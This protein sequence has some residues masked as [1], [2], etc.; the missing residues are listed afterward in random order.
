M[1]TREE[2]REERKKYEADVFYEVWRDGG[3]P[4]NINCDMV[5]DAYYDGKYPEEIANK[6]I[7]RQHEKY[8]RSY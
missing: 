8:K 3:N 1:R 6:I 5:D 2:I 4:D 7:Q